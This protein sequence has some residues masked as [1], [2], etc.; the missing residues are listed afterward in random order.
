MFQKFYERKEI[1]IRAGNNKT[2]S[3]HTYVC[4]STCLS[5]TLK[6]FMYSLYQEQRKRENERSNE[7]T[8]YFMFKVKC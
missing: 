7:K 6:I 3:S 4:Q 2:Y 8:L 5:I 1:K